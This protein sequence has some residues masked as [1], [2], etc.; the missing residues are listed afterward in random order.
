MGGAQGMRVQSEGWACGGRDGDV[1][2]PMGV[3]QEE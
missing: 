1:A 3:W 2:G